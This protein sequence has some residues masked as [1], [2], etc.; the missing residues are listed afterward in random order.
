MR[1]R[2]WTP[3]CST[4]NAINVTICLGSASTSQ[5]CEAERFYLLKAEPDS[6]IVKGKDVKVY[7]P[8]VKAG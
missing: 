4:N 6:R 7:H 3:F 5:A 1:V 8:E 2:S